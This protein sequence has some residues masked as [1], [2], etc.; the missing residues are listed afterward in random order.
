LVDRGCVTEVAF[1]S[2]QRD[3][4]L[5]PEGISGS[6]DGT[7]IDDDDFVGRVSPLLR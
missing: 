5:A 6:V 7:V 3:P 2:Y 4:R 1:V